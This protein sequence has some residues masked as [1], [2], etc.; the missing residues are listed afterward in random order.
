MSVFTY[1]GITLPYANV[2]R[3][4]QSALYDEVGQTDH[5]LTKFEIQLNAVINADYM[6]LLSPALIGP[7][8]NAITDNAADIMNVIRAELMEP[9]RRLSYRFNETEL[10]PLIDTNDPG[11]RGTVDSANGPM[12]QSC[13][14]TQLTTKT[15][16]VSYHIIAHYWENNTS[17][18]FARPYVINNTGNNVLFNRWSESVEIDNCNYTTRT[19]EGKYRIRSDNRDG[20]IADQ[21]RSRMA[22]VGVP[23]GFNRASSKYTVS[24]DGL[25]IAYTV[26][27]KEVFKNP[28]LPAFEAK[29][30]YWE[31]A[32]RFDAKRYA[33]V[34]VELKGSKTVDQAELL[35]TAVFV[36]AAKLDINGAPLGGGEGPQPEG[37]QPAILESAEVRVNMYE[38]IVSCHMRALLNVQTNRKGGAAF[39]KS[40]IAFTPFS[41]PQGTAPEPDYFDRGT[42][43]LLLQAAKYYDPSLRNTQLGAGTL[44]AGEQ[45]ATGDDNSQLDAGLLVGQAGVRREP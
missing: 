39:L 2:T 42:A 23:V 25:S 43:N 3:F 10:I 37:R 36:C 27:D 6:A 45:L 15:F 4:E 44:Q 29:G 24:P 19:R 8:G 32:T 7:A 28:P 26:V 35:E 34:R 17:L 12:P 5:F 21:M 14:I 13:L 33:D 40:A 1:N 22:V 16:L 41:D 9:R 11:G 38:N 30:E 20:I 18:G 31:T